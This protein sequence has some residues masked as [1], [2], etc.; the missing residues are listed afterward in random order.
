MNQIPREVLDSF[1]EIQGTTTLQD[2]PMDFRRIPKV[3]TSP[4]LP[5]NGPKRSK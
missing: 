2:D 1:K 4:Q 3:Q 5:G